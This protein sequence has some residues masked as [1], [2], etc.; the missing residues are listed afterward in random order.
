MA[1][2]D[3]GLSNSR[4][5][6]I[7]DPSTKLR[8]LVD[9]GAEVS[10]LTPS[11]TDRKNKQQLTLNAANKTVI[12]T[13]GKR[14]LTL[15]LGLRRSFP[16]I[17]IVAEVAVPILGAD[18]LRHYG[19]M[20]DMRR[21]LL[22]DSTT[23]LEVNCKTS[24]RPALCLTLLPPQPQNDFEI[25]IKDFP[26]VLQTSPQQPIKHTVTHH[27]QTTGPP[28]YTPTRRLSPAKL[29][30][31]KREFEHMLQLGII[32]P[33]SGSWASPLHMVPKKSGD[34]RPCGDYRSLNKMTIPD[35]YPIP[36]IQ[37]FTASLHGTNIFSK[38]D[39]VRAYHQIP[40]EPS[41]IPKTAITTPFG[42]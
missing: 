2:N 12:T 19:L 15:D 32:R 22:I 27:I 40:V 11:H 23:K 8:F 26:S 33:S 41:D 14:S 6:L 34:W 1:T 39:L 18:F 13:F 21:H 16:W 4:L 42:L 25:I 37:D 38:I 24:S 29:N 35:R 7:F 3:A 10:V 20:V 31:A 17:F 28:V 30:I 36:H 5:F 9:T